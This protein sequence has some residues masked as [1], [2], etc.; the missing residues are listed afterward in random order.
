LI[1]GVALLFKGPVL[2][3]KIW[4]PNVSPT[5]SWV[6]Y[7]L[8]G[9]TFALGSI[10]C[11]IGPFLAV[12]STTLGASL[13][14]SLLTYVLYGLGFVVTISILAIFTAL[15][16][17]LLIKK[18]RGAGG[19]LEKFMGGLM[20]LI[21]LYLIYFGINELAFQYGFGINQGIADFAFEIQGSIVEL[22]TK[23]LTAIGL[24]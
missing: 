1:F 19:A 14:E 2:L 18:I 12:T 5:G 15:S 23:I 6:T 10:S 8:Y 3:K 17:D 22:V 9:V 20:A 7:I 13:V 24:L 16:K 4:S 21:G 11:T